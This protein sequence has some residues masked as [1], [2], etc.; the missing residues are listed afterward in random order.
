MWIKA[1]KHKPKGK[2]TNRKGGIFFLGLE[3]S[4]L[5]QIRA[6][7]G[8]LAQGENFS[9]FCQCVKKQSNWQDTRIHLKKEIYNAEALKGIV[10]IVWTYSIWETY[11]SIF[12]TY[13]YYSCLYQNMC[14]YMCGDLYGHVCMYKELLHLGLKSPFPHSSRGTNATGEN[15]GCL[16]IVSVYLPIKFHQTF[17]RALRKFC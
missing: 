2:G 17:K 1:G 10:R 12:I 16:W 3:G 6:C 7:N 14:M 4:C 9:F 11:F 13:K 8:P 5:P 15:L